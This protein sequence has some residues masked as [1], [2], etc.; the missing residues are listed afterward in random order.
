MYIQVIPGLVQCIGSFE[1]I[2][3]YCN[4]S[5]N[6]EVD[7]KQ[8][9][10]HEV[11]TSNISLATLT[12]IVAR[13]VSSQIEEHHIFTLDGHDFAWNKEQPA[14]LK[15]VKMKFEQ[16]KIITIVG[17]VGSGKSTLLESILGETLSSSSVLRIESS[18]AYCAQ[19]PWLEND[20]IRANI[21]GV[22]SY[23][24]KWYDQ[25]KAYCGLVE[26]FQ[27]MA[28]G[29]RTKIGSKGLNISGGQKQRIVS[30]PFP[31]TIES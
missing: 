29:D 2:Q 28:Q 20:T 4:Y 1:R 10:A 9:S 27:T 13:N 25:V 14:V 12:P 22:S 16:R 26:D 11:Q 24:R 8:Q 18:T 31:T 23:D 21:L 19:Q 6:T 17:P 3:M 5:H 15:D 30:V 7:G